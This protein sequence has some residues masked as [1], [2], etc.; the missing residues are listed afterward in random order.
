MIPSTRVARESCC[1]CI[2]TRGLR[3]RLVLTTHYSLESFMQ[4]RSIL[5]FQIIWIA[6]LTDNTLTSN[7]S[8]SRFDH[9]ILI[10][11]IL[12]WGIDKL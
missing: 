9:P 5:T 7:E 12:K 1:C 4:R 6:L 2:D 11:Y 3:M 8:L 10:I